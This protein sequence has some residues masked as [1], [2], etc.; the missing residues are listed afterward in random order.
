[1]AWNASWSQFDPGKTTT[2]NFMTR[3]RMSFVGMSSLP[4]RRALGAPPCEQDRGGNQRRFLFRLVVFAAVSS[5][6]FLLAQPGL[7]TWRPRAMPRASEGTL[8][9]I[10]EPAPT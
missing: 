10:V 4:Q 8:S 7:L 3:L 1:M 2:P 6:R 9:V 5:R